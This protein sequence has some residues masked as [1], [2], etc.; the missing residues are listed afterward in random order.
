MT[1]EISRRAYYLEEGP[2]ALA[3]VI[4][5]VVKGGYY[6]AEAISILH[7]TKRALKRAAKR[8]EAL[9]AEIER[10]EIKQSHGPTVEFTGRLLISDEFETRGRDSLQVER[11]IW[12]TQGGA[13]IAAS[14]STGAGG[15]EDVRVAVV[16]PAEDAQASRFAV[17]SHFHWDVRAK[18]MARKLGWLLRLDVE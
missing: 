6:R 3:D 18:A 17:M 13:L 10:V 8:A 4:D 12:E 9:P 11:Q 14:F 7:D 5:L 2:E 16:E 15:R 1:E